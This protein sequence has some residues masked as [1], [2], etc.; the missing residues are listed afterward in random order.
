MALLRAEGIVAGY[1]ELE[2]LKGVQLRVE[3]Q[4]IVVII[5]PN[6]AG[7]STLVKALFG[8][9]RVKGGRVEFAGEEVTGKPPE[10]LI[11]KG[12][13]YV[14]QVNNVFQNLTV[15]EN[16][17]MGAYVLQGDLK[18][19]KE[20][21]YALFPR[22]YE[23]RGQR[24]GQLSG[25]E[26]QMVAIGRALMLS[27]KLLILDEPTAGLSPL[28]VDHLFEQVQGVNAA[29]VAVLLVE[30]NARKALALAH[31]AYVLAAG[32]NRLEGTGA[33]LL[34]DPEVARLYLGG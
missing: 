34:A 2:I 11:R 8:L 16:L 21:V 32:E 5:G 4:E 27:P 19:R 18:E 9:V 22:L 28:L 10:V 15:E 7:K 3:P 13:A 1:G 29:G 26:R 33:E 24:A 6:G 14:P 17:E 30:Q 31:R 25:G 23:R 20:R 12:M